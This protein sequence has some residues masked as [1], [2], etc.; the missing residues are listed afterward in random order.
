MHL[1]EL[2]KA[3]LATVPSASDRRPL[4]IP[5]VVRGVGCLRRCGCSS[6]LCLC[7]TAAFLA[8]HYA[9]RLRIRRQLA[10]V[11]L[12]QWKVMPFPYVPSVLGIYAESGQGRG[13]HTA[14][15]GRRGTCRLGSSCAKSEPAPSGIDVQR[16]S[17]SRASPKLCDPCREGLCPNTTTAHHRMWIFRCEGCCLLAANFVGRETEITP[18]LC[19]KQ[20]KLRQPRNTLQPLD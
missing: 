9:V 8:D 16:T 7:C 5:A 12:R 10:G 4:R 15:W 11:L 20:S 6:I 14:D 3:N 13:D 1:D 2:L 19:R 17:I 18:I